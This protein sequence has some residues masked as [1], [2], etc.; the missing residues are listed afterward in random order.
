MNSI[1]GSLCKLKMGTNFLFSILLISILVLIQSNIKDTFATDNLIFNGGFEKGD[2]RGWNVTGVYNVK[3]HNGT[4]ALE[5][6]GEY[7]VIIGTSNP[8]IIKKTTIAQTFTI[9]K[10]N[11]ADINYVFK[12]ENQSIL[13]VYLRKAD[14]TTIYN[15]TFSNESP[16]MTFNHQIDQDYSGI[17][18]VLTFEGRGYNE[19][20]TKDSCPIEP[21]KEGPDQG[22]GEGVF[23]VYYYPHIDEVSVT[24]RIALFDN[25]SSLEADTTEYS[26]DTSTLTITTT[27]QDP[28]TS[29][30][31][32]TYS[33]K[34]YELL[35]PIIFTGFA[36]IVA[37]FLLRRRKNLKRQVSTSD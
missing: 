9:P 26:T 16:W 28:L 29:P 10:N 12:I 7:Y 37:I 24:P 5:E 36:T 14:G 11:V 32:V 15:W 13:N 34:K 23:R 22:C 25:P 8:N 33:L 2:L 21:N 18:L 4:D 31:G 1:N 30:S 3:Q 17:P 6:A 19:W 35:F 27:N 20:L